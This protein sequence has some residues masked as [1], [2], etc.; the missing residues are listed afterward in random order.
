M[1]DVER[2]RLRPPSDAPR[3][4]EAFY[5]LVDTETILVEQI[6]SS[7]A[8][9]DELYVQECDEWV[10]VLEGAATLE[11]DGVSLDL[12]AGEWIVLPAGVPHRVLRS[13]QGTSWLAVQTPPAGGDQRDL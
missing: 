4:G 2:G 3:D 10:A 13:V 5:A 7:A 6:L 12:A 11:V 8:P 9:P 1:A